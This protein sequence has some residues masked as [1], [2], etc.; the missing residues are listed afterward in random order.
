MIDTPSSARYALL[1][2]S[3]INVKPIRPACCLIFHA[4]FG[5]PMLTHKLRSMMS[6]PMAATSVQTTTEDF[7]NKTFFNFVLKG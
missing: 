7:C 5:R 2:I 6:N 3:I 1:R 4:V